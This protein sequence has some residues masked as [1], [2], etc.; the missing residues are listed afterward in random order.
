MGQSKGSHQLWLRAVDQES[1][2]SC[3]QQKLICDPVS[4]LDV[5]FMLFC[6]RILKTCSDSVF[7]E[8]Q[9]AFAGF[10]SCNLNIYVTFWF[11]QLKSG[12]EQLKTPGVEK[13]HPADVNVGYLQVSPKETKKILKYKSPSIYWFYLFTFFLCPL[14][15]AAFPENTGLTELS[16]SFELVPGL[17]AQV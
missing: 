8:N 12:T 10:I 1:S 6:D 17:T 13:H 14:Q 11:K 9:Q 4:K 2:E 15:R 7:P 16:G 3:S 5:L